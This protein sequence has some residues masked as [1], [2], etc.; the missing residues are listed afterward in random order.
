MSVTAVY[1]LPVPIWISNK[2]LGE[3]ISSGLGRVTFDVFMP[4][5]GGPVGAP[6]EAPDVDV[7]S[8]MAETS[9]LLDW[10]HRYAAFP[11]DPD[12]TALRRVVV[13]TAAVERPMDTTYDLA[14]AIDPWFDAVRTWAETM[15]GQDLDPN[16]QV[17][18]ATSHGARLTLLDPAPTI[19]GPIALTLSTPRVMPVGAEE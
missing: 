15:T 6:P 5:I 4:G 9:E 18:S 17:F 2:V 16:H 7:P 12:S 14:R 3:C 8:T 13:Q 10:T 19:D 11:S 1:E